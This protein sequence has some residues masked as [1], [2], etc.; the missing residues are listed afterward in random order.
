M[1]IELHLDADSCSDR[2]AAA[3][4][5]HGLDVLLGTKELADGASD[6]QQLQFAVS[7]GRPIVTANLKDFARMNDKWSAA[8]REH[9]GIIIWFQ[10]AR[11]PEAVA[12]LIADLCRGNTPASMQ[13]M[14]FFV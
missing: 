5:R 9:Q 6:E 11:S 7:V 14:V 13:N 8:G 12:E 3:L 4:V 10:R 1:V 2:L